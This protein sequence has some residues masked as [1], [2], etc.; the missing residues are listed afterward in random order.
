MYSKASKDPSIK[1]SLANGPHT[2]SIGPRDNPVATG[3]LLRRSNACA[4]PERDDNTNGLMVEATSQPSEGHE[5]RGWSR[6]SQWQTHKS[7]RCES[8][9]APLLEF[10][11]A[12]KS[13]PPPHPPPPAT[14]IDAVDM[15][16]YS[17]HQCPIPFLKSSACRRT[18]MKTAL[19]LKPEILR[20]IRKWNTL[21]AR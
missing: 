4:Q 17:P 20:N 5:P 7:I 19:A 2:S 1:A 14:Y 3:G 12:S 21:G 11:P 6:K 9:F 13:I 10:S 16:S 18:S 8:N 15:A